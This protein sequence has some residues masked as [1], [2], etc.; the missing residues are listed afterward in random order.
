MIG[1]EAPGN[2]RLEILREKFSGV[3]GLKDS[4]IELGKSSFL[5][6]Q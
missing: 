4:G 1:Q 2:L 5:V 6:P 3:V